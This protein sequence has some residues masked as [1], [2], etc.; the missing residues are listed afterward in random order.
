[1]FANPIIVGRGALILNIQY[2]NIPGLHDLW[3]SKV[4][5]PK[6]QKYKKKTPKN[7]ANTDFI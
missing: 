3:V 1:M 4:T 5:P 7:T 6:D 2:L